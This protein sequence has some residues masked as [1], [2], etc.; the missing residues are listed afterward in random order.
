MEQ[1]KLN[2]LNIYLKTAAL[3]PIGAYLDILKIKIPA[4]FESFKL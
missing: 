2:I 4:I 3:P 1:M